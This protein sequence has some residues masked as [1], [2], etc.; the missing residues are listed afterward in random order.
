MEKNVVMNL[1]LIGIIIGLTSA[2]IMTAFNGREFP[3]SKQPYYYQYKSADY[4]YGEEGTRYTFQGIYPIVKCIRQSNGYYIE[5]K[6]IGNFVVGY[7][8]IISLVLP[9]STTVIPCK[10]QL[11]EI[12]YFGHFIGTEYIY[13]LHL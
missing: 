5:Y 1:I 3:S 12:F 11:L 7:N 13:R 10:I 2:L 8:T 9:Y 4:A 6:R